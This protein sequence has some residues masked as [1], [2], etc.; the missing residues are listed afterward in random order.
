MAV[1]LTKLTYT[2][3]QIGQSP[4]QHASIASLPR[5]AE[6]RGS[7]LNRDSLAYLDRHG[8]IALVGAVLHV[9]VLAS[10]KCDL[11]VAAARF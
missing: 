7:C 3:L 9:A 6:Q 11:A 2:V 10:T 5:A 8:L 4:A 1:E